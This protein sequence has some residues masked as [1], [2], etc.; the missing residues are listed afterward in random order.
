M[1]L[2]NG[3]KIGISTT[4]GTAGRGMSA[5]LLFVDE[6]D[7]IECVEGSVLVDIKNK[8]TQEVKKITIED[9]YKKTQ[10]E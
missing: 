7:W 6:A 8:K 5:N 9:L 1:E 2:Q 3:S 10:K 4:T